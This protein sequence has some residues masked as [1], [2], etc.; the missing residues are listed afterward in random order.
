MAVREAPSHEL[1]ER[2]ANGVPIVRQSGELDLATAGELC[3]RVDAARAAGFR[4]LVIDLTRV[5]LCDSTGLR[6]LIRPAAEV[7]ASAGRVVVVPPADGTV[8]RT[9][10]LAGATELLPLRATT[11]EALAALGRVNRG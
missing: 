5:R 9:F 8:A 4:R 6:A 11:T 3:A 7:L 1:S 10:A 2:D